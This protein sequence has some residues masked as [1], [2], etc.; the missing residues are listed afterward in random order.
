MT[1]NMEDYFNTQFDEDIPEM[2]Y[3]YTCNLCRKEWE[4]DYGNW[5]LESENK[6]HLI[7]DHGFTLQEIEETVPIYESGLTE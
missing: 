2:G 6:K 1:M 4:S 7:N 3:L 5:M